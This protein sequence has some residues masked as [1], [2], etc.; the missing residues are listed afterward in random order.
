MDMER[1]V[2][3]SCGGVLKDISAGHT[4]ARWVCEYCGA[5]YMRDTDMPGIRIVEVRPSRFEVIKAEQVITMNLYPE[6]D[7]EDIIKEQMVHKLAKR[8]LE[9][10]DI[11]KEIDPYLN[12]LRYQ[13]RIRVVRDNNDN[14]SF[15][16]GGRMEL[17]NGR[18]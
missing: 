8:I 13:A 1:M 5:E 3:K 15:I 4:G 2:C 17:N 10:A 16:R 14:P 11:T 6:G 18:G 12:A 9:C 7:I